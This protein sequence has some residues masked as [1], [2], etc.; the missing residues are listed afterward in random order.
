MRSE[1]TTQGCGESA[2]IGTFWRRKSDGKV[3]ELIYVSPERNDE[4]ARFQLKPAEAKNRKNTRWINA[5][6]LPERYEPVDA[7]PPPTLP[8]R[9]RDEYGVP[10]S[11][12]LG[13]SVEFSYGWRAGPESWAGHAVEFIRSHPDA[14]WS[15]SNVPETAKR[16]KQDGFWYLTLHAKVDGL[17]ATIKGPGGWTTKQGQALTESLKAA[18]AETQPPERPPDHVCPR[19]AY[20]WH[21]S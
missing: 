4:P 8:E 13:A 7:P 19:C 16:E 5:D 3:F 18:K 2:S 9:L 17:S 10:D 11:D 21:D 1:R 20:G 15:W 12:S 14:T 6:N